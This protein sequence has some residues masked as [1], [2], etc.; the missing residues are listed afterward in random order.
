MI[1]LYQLFLELRPAFCVTP[2]S[3]PP[4][5]MKRP[6]DEPEELHRGGR[7]Q[8]R[9][10][11]ELA[12]RA[13]LVGV[14]E[15]K[16]L[17]SEL[18]LEL[19]KEWAWGKISAVTVQQFAARGLEDCVKSLEL[20]GLGPENAP[21][22]LRALGGLGQG[23]R[24]SNKCN[25]QL[26]RWLG[27]PLIPEPTHARVNVLVLK[28]R[29][30]GVRIV[31]AMKLP[32]FLPH[33]MFSFFWAKSKKLF[34]TKFLGPDGADQKLEDFWTELERRGDPKLVNHPM[35]RRKG[36]KRKAIPITIHGDGVPIIAV[37]KPGTKSFDN[38][39]WQSL[40]ACGS[41][42]SIKLWIT[43]VFLQNLC[44]SENQDCDT[45]EQIWTVIV[46]SLRAA[47]AGSH[48]N[49]HWA[50][51]WPEHM[52]GDIE[53]AGSSLAGGYFLVLWLVKADWDYQAKIFKLLHYARDDFCDFCPADI[54][55]DKS[56]WPSN[57]SVG[58]PWKIL[59]RTPQQWRDSN[60]GMHILFLTFSFLSV[61]NCYPDELHVLHIGVEQYFLGCVL[62]LLCFRVLRQTPK[63]N[64]NTVWDL[65]LEEY[66][67]LKSSSQY[68]NLGISSFVNPQKLH[69]SWPKLKG[70]GAEAKSLVKPMLNV[71]RKLKR[72]GADSLH[73]NHVER[74][75][76]HLDGIVNILDDYK[77]D[78]WLPDGES[79][80]FKTLTDDFL[81][82]YTWLGHASDDR[83]DRLFSAVP[84]LH[85]LWHMAD[86]SQYLNPRRAA[87]FIDEHYQ[88]I[89]KTLGQKCIAGTKLHKVV[90][91]MAEKYRWGMTFEY[92]GDVV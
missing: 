88:K 49:E 51:P 2:S 91:K 59:C 62:W 5:K 64:M 55:L 39:S 45:M 67:S 17:D 61:H 69:T 26:K 11:A 74:A 57:F 1:E 28:P 42:L 34:N 60:P 71:W 54:S 52:L 16:L 13:E 53:L 50:G 14:V 40:L 21:A 72:G 10:Q 31:Q 83:G 32:F 89:M 8:R 77:Y 44:T 76:E 46:W 6:A 92:F 12:A 23:G 58:A 30:R 63:T 75:L 33:I 22:S 87:N 70:R 25:Q 27:V 84:K 56:M 82:E 37:G 78:M 3:R 41:A 36:W 4:P 43:G 85:M 68:T 7:R 19:V 38:I 79:E 29:S 48:P 18:A 73:D 80:H 81:N 47:Y 86:L 90:L 20:G 15:Q 35:K 65:I 66:T 9:K 24:A